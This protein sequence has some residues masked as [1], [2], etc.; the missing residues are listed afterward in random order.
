MK[1]KY[2]INPDDPQTVERP[3]V[4]MCKLRGTIG[5]WKI[6]ILLDG[7]YPFVVTSKWNI[8]R[9]RQMAVAACKALNC[10]YYKREL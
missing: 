9:A 7:C 2:L 3:V 6:R 4:E 10:K 1:P 5:G 8:T